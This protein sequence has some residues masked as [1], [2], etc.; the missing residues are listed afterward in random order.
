MFD[1][2]TNFLSQIMNRSGDLV[3]LESPDHTAVVYA[4]A[5]KRIATQPTAANFRWCAEAAC[6]AAVAAH[7]RGERLMASSYAIAAEAH[8]DSASSCAHT[9]SII[10]HKL[11]KAAEAIGNIYGKLGD[12][13]DPLYKPYW[14]TK[15]AADRAREQSEKA[16]AEVKAA[17]GWARM[18]ARYRS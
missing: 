14:D 2:L 3:S 11:A 18:C 7:E 16:V 15:A 1:N 5:L 17:S 10:A 6:R 12:L 4:E 13:N 9:E 8:A